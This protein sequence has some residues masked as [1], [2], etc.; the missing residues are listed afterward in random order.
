MNETTRLAM[1]RLESIGKMNSITSQTGVPQQQGN[2]SR[3]QFVRCG[4]HLPLVDRR[5][6]ALLKPSKQSS[7]MHLGHD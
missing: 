6:K 1:R 5:S 4:G 7:I 3:K 2:G